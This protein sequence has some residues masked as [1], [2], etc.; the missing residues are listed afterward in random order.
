MSAA[1]AARHPRTPIRAF[2]CMADSLGLGEEAVDHEIHA[3]E[4]MTT[5]VRGWAE[6]DA[7]FPAAFRDDVH[8]RADRGRTAWVDDLQRVA[9]SADL[10]SRLFPRSVSAHRCLRRFSPRISAQRRSS[11]DGR[12]GY[13]VF[14][15][16]F[17]DGRSWRTIRGTQSAEC[18]FFS[19]IGPRSSILQ[20][21]VTPSS[22]KLASWWP[23]AGS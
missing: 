12:S 16:R 23:V 8:P 1:Y 3:H 7:A 10:A 20:R 22:R 18:T 2:I 11:C 15:R 6:D 21:A 13:A 9:G 17:R 4:A 5:L 14:L 19:R